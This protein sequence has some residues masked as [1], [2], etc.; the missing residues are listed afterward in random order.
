[1]D[2]LS[3]TTLHRLPASIIKPDY[4]RAAVATGIVH[5][6]LGAFHR[7]HQAVYTDGLLKHDPRWGI[8]GVSLR[9]PETRD[10]LEPQGGLYSVTASNGEGHQLRIIGALTGLAVAP[11]DPAGLLARLAD[12]AVRIVSTTVTEKGYSHDPATGALRAD[13]PDIQHDISNLGLPRTTLCFIV[14]GLR[15]RRL[16]GLPPYTVLA[17]DNL[18]ANGHTLRGLAIAFAELVDRD[19]ARWIADNVRF[20]STMVDRIVPATTDADRADVSAA[21]GLLDAWPVVTEPFS[22][23]VIEDDL[24]GA[25]PAW[26]ISG[27]QFVRDVAPFELMKLRLLNGAHSTLAYLGYLMGCETVAA[28]MSEPDLAGLV[29]D[30]MR[31][32]VTPTLP[33]LGGFDV[34]A[35]RAAL[36]QRFRNPALKHR[37]AQIAMDGSQK[38]PQ[39]LLGTI[40]DRLARDLPITCL[41]LAVAGWMRYVSGTD[42]QRRPIDLRDPLSTQLRALADDAGPVAQRLVPAL[43]SLTSVFG[44]DLRRDPRF[45]SAVETALDSLF[46]QGARATVAQTRQAALS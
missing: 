27:A 28:A 20:P 41:A 44:S 8:L 14:S 32:E 1:M 18:P 9:S 21:I 3:P 5:L 19:L 6:G 16:H 2:R 26:D 38:L 22:Q 42:E 45:T 43:L 34:A 4:D 46:K 23:W 37:T 13:D 31:E 10:A 30:M 29:E 17:C 15:L 11:E 40:S 33:A 35:Y 25:R 39:R 7:G 24:G 12:P 36:L